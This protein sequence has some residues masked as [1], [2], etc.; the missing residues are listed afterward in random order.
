MNDGNDFWSHVQFQFQNEGFASVL[1]VKSTIEND[2]RLAREL[3]PFLTAP[4]CITQDIKVFSRFETMGS[5][6]KLNFVFLMCYCHEL[7][8]R[9][10]ES[11]MENELYKQILF[12]FIETP[13][14]VNHQPVEIPHSSKDEQQEVGIFAT[15][16]TSSSFFDDLDRFLTMYPRQAEDTLRVHFPVTPFQAFYNSIG[17]FFSQHR[18]P[19]SCEM[20]AR[21][22]IRPYIADLKASANR[23]VSDALIH[24]VKFIPEVFVK[25]VISKDGRWMG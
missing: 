10:P 1:S 6:A 15:D 17:G 12:P 23:L 20:V 25:E 18:S 8:G 19:D 2:P 16:P 11:I 22:V 9:I 7:I 5:N 24:A 21:F 4:S 13:K 14:R 3:I